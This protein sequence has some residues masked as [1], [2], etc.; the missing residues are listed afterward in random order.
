MLATSVGAGLA[1]YR[2]GVNSLTLFFMEQGANPVLTFLGFW[3]FLQLAA[4][5]IL[6]LGGIYV[7]Y[8]LGRAAAGMDRMATAMEQWVQMQQS[9][10]GA[11]AYIPPAPVET[12]PAA[13]ETL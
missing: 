7:L 3:M 6:I 10:Q 9:A 13:E 11:D 12:A 5:I 8:C 1:P 2:C 4:S